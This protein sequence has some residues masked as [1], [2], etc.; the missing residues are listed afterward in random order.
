ME[1][2]LW[3]FFN[4]LCWLTCLGPCTL[5]TQQVVLGFI[6]IPFLY[7]CM[8]GRVLGCRRQL[9]T[10]RRRQM[11]F[12]TAYVFSFAVYIML[13]ERY[14]VNKAAALSHDQ[15]CQWLMSQQ[16]AVVPCNWS[17]YG[18]AC[19][20]GKLQNKKKLWKTNITF[21]VKKIYKNIK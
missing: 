7:Q 20:S 4:R 10:P 18:C 5:N 17:S 2:Y 14:V 15:L 6:P 21:Y 3:Q 13:I 1:N 12:L 9:G 16:G 8:A 11:W 19:Y